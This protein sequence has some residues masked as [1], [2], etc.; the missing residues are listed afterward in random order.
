MEELMTFITTYGFGW[1]TLF[2]VIGIVLLGI[3][4]YCNLFSKIAEGSRHYIYLAISIGFSVVATLIY[5]LSAGL[6]SW[7]MFIGICTAVFALNQTFYNLFKITPVNKLGEKLLDFVKALAE[8]RKH[9][10]ADTPDK[11]ADSDK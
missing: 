3:M 1:I 4:K 11:P 2:A 7:I 6:F 5:L 8:K 10:K 9:D